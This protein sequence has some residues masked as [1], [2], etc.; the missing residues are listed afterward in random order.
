MF[1]DF[2][3][4]VIKAAVV[5]VCNDGMTL[6]LELVKVVDDLAAKKVLPSSS[7]GLIDDDLSTLCI[8]TLHYSLNTRLTEVVTV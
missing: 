2:A 6:F 8:N 4:H 7:L 5:T 3:L 1:V